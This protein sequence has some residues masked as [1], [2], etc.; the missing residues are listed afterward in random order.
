ME[1]VH[2]TTREFNCLKKMLKDWWSN[3]CSDDRLLDGLYAPEGSLLQGGRCNSGLLELILQDQ[4]ELLQILADDVRNAK[5]K[6]ILDG[7][8]EQSQ[9]SVVDETVLR[10][11]NEQR[12]HG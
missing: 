1:E 10:Q 4:I 11:Q 12:V 8:R 6:L 3:S 7:A 5:L 2:S 9:K